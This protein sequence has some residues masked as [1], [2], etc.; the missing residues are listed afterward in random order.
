ML[1]LGFVR[2]TALL[3]NRT[4]MQDRCTMRPASATVVRFPLSDMHGH[5]GLLQQPP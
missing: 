1:N 3:A 2:G 4:S 5:T